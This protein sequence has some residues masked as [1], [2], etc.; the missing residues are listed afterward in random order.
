MISKATNVE[1]V[2]EDK[3]ALHNS[4][5]SS[6]STIEKQTNEPLMVWN[7]K[8]VNDCK[9]ELWTQIQ[10]RFNASIRTPLTKHSNFIEC[11]F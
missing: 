1:S 11:V 5:S 9:E 7:I 10:Y 2:K 3:S 6:V 8:S 4:A